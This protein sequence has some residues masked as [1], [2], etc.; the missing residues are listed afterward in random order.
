[1]NNVGRVKKIDTTEE[2]VKNNQNVVIAKTPRPRGSEDLFQVM[3]Y[4]IDDQENLIECFQGFN[5][6][7]IFVWYYYVMKFSGENVV[8]HL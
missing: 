8:S 2:I 5:S 3:I 7:T 6:H 4:V 1:M